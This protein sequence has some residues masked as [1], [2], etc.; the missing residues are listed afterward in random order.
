MAADK[1][2]EEALKVTVDTSAAEKGLVQVQKV[3]DSTLKTM[4]KLT[5]PVKMVFDAVDKATGVM[6]KIESAAL[7]LVHKPWDMIVKVVDFA[8]PALQGIATAAANT[9]SA[10]STATAVAGTA[11][12]GLGTSSFMAAA[13]VSEMN[14]TLGAL[15]KANDL[16][17]ESVNETVLEVKGMGIEMATA[18]STVA[19]MI[20]SELDL[21]KASQL[22]RIAQDAAVI[23][24]VNSSEALDRLIHGITTQQTDVLRGIGIQVDANA[25]QEEYA[26]TLKKTTG[27]LTSTEKSAA[28]LNAVLK[29]GEKIAGSYEAAMQEP[30]KVLRSFPRLF[31]DIKVAIGETML[32]AFGPFILATYDMVKAFSKAVA[33]GGPLNELFVT[34]GNSLARLMGP[35]TSLVESMTEWIKALDAQAVGEFVDKLEELA[36]LLMTLGFGLAAKGGANIKALLGP[37]GML[38]P[39]INPIVAAVAGLALSSDT[40]RRNIKDLGSAIFTAFTKD[41]G[42]IG[43][44]YDLMT[45]MFGPDLANAVQ[46]FLQI[47]MEFMAKV[48]EAGGWVKF[49]GDAFTEFKKQI[50]P[51]LDVLSKVLVEFL[52]IVAEQMP[53]IGRIVHNLADAFGELVGPVL[54]AIFTFKDFD[55]AERHIEKVL[56]KLEKMSERL[57]KLSEWV[58][59]HGE[60]V[61]K[62]LKGLALWDIG[63][64]VLGGVGKGAGIAL[65]VI[66]SIAG[67]LGKIGG[68]IGKLIGLVSKGGGLKGILAV[69]PGPLKTVAMLFMAW[70]GP[71]K[72]AATAVLALIP[73]LIK[74]WRTNEDFRDAMSGIWDGIKSIIQSAVKIIVALW[75]GILQPAIKV[76]A[77]WWQILKPVV[78]DVIV[79]IVKV[80]QEAVEFLAGALETI[81]TWVAK[82]QTAWE[83]SGGSIVEFIKN[84]AVEIW[85]GFWNSLTE[86]LGQIREWPAQIKAAW[87]G[88]NTL[89]SYIF[90]LGKDIVE[91]LWNGLVT[92]ITRFT[93]WL[94]EVWNNI[95]QGVAG[96]IENVKNIGSQAASGLW[97]GL[98]SGVAGI[99]EWAGEQAKKLIPDPMEGALG[100]ASPSK[101]ME[102]LGENAGAGLVEGLDATTAAVVVTSTDLGAGVVAGFST[103]INEEVPGLVSTMGNM[104]MSTVEGLLMGIQGAL[105]ALMQFWITAMEAIPQSAADVLGIRSPSRVMQTIGQQVMAG[106]IGGMEAALPALQAVANEIS[107]TITG[108]TA[109]IGAA[110]QFTSGY[111]GTAD[112]WINDAIAYTGVDQSWAAGLDTIIKHESNYDPTASN[113]WDVNAQAGDASV[114]LMQLTGSNRAAYTPAGMDPM[115]PTAQV[116]AGIRYIEDRYGDISN[117]PGVKS[118]NAGGAYKP[119]DEGGWLMPGLTA[120]LN[121]TGQPE[122][123]LAPGENSIEVNVGGIT[124]N[125]G[126]GTS[127]AA[128]AEEIARQLA[129]RLQAALSN[130]A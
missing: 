73:A 56:R 107:S 74:L 60:Q 35:V 71:I 17:T 32:D 86:G 121:N 126:P 49:L 41:A 128:L 61:L 108:A 92:D 69:L 114:G 2:Y 125:A 45:E 13:E 21:S 106:L 130:M 38:I 5:K 42:A 26:K 93:G 129:P 75:E 80:V 117:V 66:G 11:I 109:G 54:A 82:I 112:Q 116:I 51:A 50:Q 115:D 102:E 98:K 52:G 53:T 43:V 110:G 124:I 16:A 120:A 101:V 118:V 9:I 90:Q 63:G 127:G 1:T 14:A 72:L 123:V 29:E 27:E 100:I 20:Q 39:T 94:G 15:A 96:F 55:D 103:G 84:L 4:T 113:M 18:Q 37:L 36:P 31:N 33:A 3:A 24:Q 81:A 105:P 70:P 57:V 77:E 97:E 79:I 47:L 19:K 40:A 68:I 48:R 111:G 65:K 62:F 64:K 28:M 122:R 104:G 89:L 8:T 22:A 46:P 78:I 99:G 44:V 85:N 87:E 23:G 76:L 83:E 25:A 34:I 6:K 58:G 91:M 10:V 95:S 119:Y 30:G 59:S 12:V 7:K 67:G 88:D